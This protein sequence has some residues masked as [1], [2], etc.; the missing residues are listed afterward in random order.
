MLKAT[1]QH[2]RNLAYFAT[3]YKVTMLLIRY[4]N[5]M[6]SG[7]EGAYDSF[8]AGLVGGYTVFGKGRQGSVNKQVEK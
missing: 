4:T 7:K 1:R 8:F 3:V 5:P 2:A 6:N